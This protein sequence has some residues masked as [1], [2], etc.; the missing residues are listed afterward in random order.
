M[1]IYRCNSFIAYD[2]LQVEYVG[3]KSMPKALNN[4]AESDIILGKL[5]IV[6]KVIYKK[7]SYI[8][9]V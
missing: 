3:K 2:S 5:G 6:K 9:T 1:I 8:H 7:T 4:M